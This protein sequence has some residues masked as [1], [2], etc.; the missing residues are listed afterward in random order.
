MRKSIATVSLSGSLSEKLTA[1][2]AAGFEGVEI[3][4]NDLIASP[5]T[6]EDVRARVADLGRGPQREGEVGPDP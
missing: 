2:A 1:V 3:F 4:E 6:P 5:L